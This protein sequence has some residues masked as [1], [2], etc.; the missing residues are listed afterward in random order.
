MGLLKRYNPLNDAMV[1]LRRRPGA[2]IVA[3]AFVV[4]PLVAFLLW[5]IFQAIKTG[6][7][8]D[9][10]TS[11][12]WLGRVGANEILLTQLPLHSIQTYLVGMVARLEVTI[13]QVLDRLMQEFTTILARL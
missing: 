9:G 1:S 11:L 2:F 13:P 8:H 12:Y 6:F 7:V 4:I 3:V 5:P 10:Q